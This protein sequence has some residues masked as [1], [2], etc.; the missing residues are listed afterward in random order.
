MEHERKLQVTTTL[1]LC[2]HEGDSFAKYDIIFPPSLSF[3]TGPK[4]NVYVPL[5]EY[6]LF[7][8][9]KKKKPKAPLTIFT[10]SDIY[11][12]IILFLKK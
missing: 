6:S 5:C 1:L 11:V 12:Y 9:T 7:Y 10:V 8:Y 2:K 3:K 4:T